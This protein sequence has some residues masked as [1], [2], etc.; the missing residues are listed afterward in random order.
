MTQAN[1]FTIGSD[2][3]CTDGICGVL[4]RVVIDPVA[5]TVTHVVVEPKHQNDAGRLVALTLLDSTSDEIRLRCTIAEYDKLD[6]AE[7]T[8]FLPDDEYASFGA[9]GP[10]QA[11]IWP[12]YGLGAG[13]FGT[14]MWAGGTDHA[15]E[16]VTTDTVPTGE[17]A[18]YRG[19]QVHA[20]DGEIGQVHGL[21]VGGVEHHVTHVLLQEG[22]LFGRK[23]VAIPISAVTDVAAGI[24]LNI[25]K[26]QVRSL[27]SVDLAQPL[28]ATTS[29]ATASHQG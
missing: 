18:V 7:E 12:Y 5:E 26:D 4:S 29:Q 6:R 27:P 13:A 23:E 22:H 20:T 21:V 10:G 9:Y 16:P 25:T 17:V 2:A 24:H 15:S 1:L 8:H 19:D 14:S 11:Y 3:H 28:P